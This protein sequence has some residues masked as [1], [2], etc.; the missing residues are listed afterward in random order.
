M[1]ADRKK[2]RDFGAVV[3]VAT[4]GLLTEAAYSAN[5]Q[6]RGWIRSNEL[7]ETAYTS[8]SLQGLTYNKVMFLLASSSHKTPSTN[9]KKFFSDYQVL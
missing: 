8:N 9:M 3:Q 4:K 1:A 6:E 7:S 5:V 2:Y